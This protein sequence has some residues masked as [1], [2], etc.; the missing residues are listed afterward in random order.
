MLAQL[1]QYD[2]TSHNIELTDNISTLA[3]SIPLIAD[4]TRT[5]VIRQNLQL[6]QPKSNTRL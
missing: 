4:D 2:W 1:Q 6:F 3:D 5:Q